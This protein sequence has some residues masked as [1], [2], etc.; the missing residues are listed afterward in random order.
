MPALAHSQIALYADNTALCTES[1]NINL[2]IKKLQED[3]QK[4][5]EWKL[6]RQKLIKK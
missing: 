2:A 1:V 6:G 4:I 3:L 5:I